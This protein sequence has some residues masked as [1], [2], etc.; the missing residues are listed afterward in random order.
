MIGSGYHDCVDFT[1][2]QELSEISMTFDR[3]ADQGAS[4]LEPASMHFGHRSHVNVQLRLKI[5]DMTFANQSVANESNTYALIGAENPAV[6]SGGQDRG[7]AALNELPPAQRQPAGF[8]F[9]SN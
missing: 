5:E 4:F 6:S 3:G 1:I 9:A 2:I 7:R 8:H